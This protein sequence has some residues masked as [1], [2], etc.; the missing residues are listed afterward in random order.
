M[1][2]SIRYTIVSIIIIFELQTR[3]RFAAEIVVGI[4]E[5]LQPRQRTNTLR[6]LAGEFVLSDIQLLKA[7]HIPYRIRQAPHQV[8]RADV[9]NRHFRQ[10]PDLLWQTSGQTRVHQNYFIERAGHLLDPRRQASLQIV[11]SQDQ[12]RNRRVPKI[13]RQLELEIVVV[14]EQRVEFLVEQI[15]GNVAVELVVSDI[16]KLQR[17]EAEDDGGELAG[18]MV[19]ADVELVE[20]VEIT[21][22]VGEGAFEA[23]GAEVEQGEVGEEA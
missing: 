12:N 1:I 6:N 4:S 17:R 16:E 15:V 21:E 3:A 14:Y 5:V 8:V 9:K 2:R 11:I 10:L 18:E 7:M 23:V 13:L 19:V 22:G 20:E